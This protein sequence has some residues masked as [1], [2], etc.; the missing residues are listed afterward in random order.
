MRPI[1]IIIVVATLS[2]AAFS[3][4]CGAKSTRAKRYELRGRV[5][6]D[7]RENNEL[8]V[9]HEDI[10]GLMDAMT[11]SFPADKWVID[12]A[13]PG[14]TITA[15][16]VV[17]SGTTRLENVGISKAASPN[18]PD[19]EN[20]VEG[21]AIGSVLPDLKFVDQSNR[22]VALRDLADGFLVV[23]FIYSRCP[24]PDYCP[25]MNQRFQE[26]NTAL[27]ADSQL[28]RRV[29]LLSVTLDPAYDTPA[30]LDAYS[31]PFRGAKLAVRDWQFVTGE[32]TTIGQLASFLGLVYKE[33]EG[34][35]VHS[36]RT[37]VVAPG[38][39]IVRVFRGNEWKADELLGSIRN[40]QK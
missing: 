9:A 22:P 15:D 36:L 7:D 21:A 10:P 38:G 20:T 31:Q 27:A 34:L 3:G 35:V 26:L 2:A 40:A 19:P 6:E 14:D 11:M 28:A 13:A 1:A 12:A 8:G 4:G 24:L 29:R 39:T 33:D 17:D 5:V 37:A 25:L 18:D 23:T 16:L 32:P 30:V